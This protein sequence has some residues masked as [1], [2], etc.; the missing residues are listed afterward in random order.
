MKLKEKIGVPIK[1]FALSCDIM[2]KT[3]K[4]TDFSAKFQ[5]FFR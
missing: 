1:L 5:L 3:Q 2:T 4:Y